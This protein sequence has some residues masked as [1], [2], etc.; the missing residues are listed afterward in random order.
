MDETV[1]LT[2]RFIGLTLDSLGDNATFLKMVFVENGAAQT[3]CPIS[4][5]VANQDRSSDSLCIPSQDLTR[6]LPDSLNVQKVSRIVVV[7]MQ[8]VP[9]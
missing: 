2:L 4:V 9:G 1:S 8:H 6:S 5:E 3:E 7:I